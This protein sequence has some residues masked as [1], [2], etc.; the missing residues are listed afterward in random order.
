MIARTRERHGRHEVPFHILFK[1]SAGLAMLSLIA[2]GVLD[3]IMQYS[4]S[5]FFKV[6]AGLLGALAGYISARHFW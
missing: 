3:G 6:I 1:S 4:V 2:V 5:D